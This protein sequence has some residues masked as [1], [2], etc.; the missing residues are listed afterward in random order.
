M[1]ILL[2]LILNKG[3]ICFLD[4]SHIWCRLPGSSDF[5]LVIGRVLLNKSC[6]YSS[7]GKP[8]SRLPCLSEAYRSRQLRPMLVS[9]ASASFAIVLRDG[10]LNYRSRSLTYVQSAFYEHLKFHQQSLGEVQ[11]IDVVGAEEVDLLAI[12]RQ[13]RRRTHLCSVAL[14]QRFRQSAGYLFQQWTESLAIFRRHVRECLRWCG[15]KFES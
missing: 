8:V 10:F 14:I 1:G 5:A 15:K 2:R 13:K 4:L 6:E 3:S 12:R 11:A 7:R 9:K